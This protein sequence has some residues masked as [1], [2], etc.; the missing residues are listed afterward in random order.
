[1]TIMSLITSQYMDI[2]YY[3]KLLTSDR[4]QGL[5]PECDIA[6]I[7]ILNFKKYCVDF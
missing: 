6:N 5:S 2:F 4:T 7:L 1:M 3:H